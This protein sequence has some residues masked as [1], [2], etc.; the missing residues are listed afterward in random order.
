MAFNLFGMKFGKE[1]IPMTQNIPTSN[2]TSFAFS[3]PFMK[4]GS[5]NLSLPVV[6]RYYT[7]NGVVRFGEDNLYPQLLNQMY[8][9][10][11]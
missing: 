7:Q 2:G 10:R 3:T 8:Y 5:S 9:M 1:Y 6:D 11:Y 4:V